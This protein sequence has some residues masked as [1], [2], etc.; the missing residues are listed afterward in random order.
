MLIR[1]QLMQYQHLTRT[2]MARRLSGSK[3]NVKFFKSVCLQR[4]VTQPHLV[5]GYNL[6]KNG[7][8]HS[9]LKSNGES[10]TKAGEV[11]T[12]QLPELILLVH[13]EKK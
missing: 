1:L 8:G 11:F 3:R 7:W 2:N 12:D 4:Y 10:P 5:V 9:L 6:S 13:I